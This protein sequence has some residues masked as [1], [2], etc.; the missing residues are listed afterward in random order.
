MEV[1]SLDQ[2]PRYVALS[3]EWGDPK[4]EESWEGQKVVINGEEKTITKNLYATLI[5]LRLQISS[6]PEPALETRFW[7]DA[8]CVNQ[9]DDD[10]KA[11]QVALMG[12]I[13]SMA[14]CVM[15]WVGVDRDNS[16]LALAFIEEAA[17]SPRN[18]ERNGPSEW[19]MQR[20]N[21]PQYL[22]HWMAF[23]HLLQGH[24]G[25][26]SGSPR[27]LSLRQQRSL[28]VATIYCR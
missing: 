22:S 2:G 28:S 18:E 8:V 4:G 14:C 9:D 1:V 17:R 15:L 10:E 16:N 12:K 3:Y 23:G 13:Y 21:D 7:I 26:V 6:A 20:L 27:R 24:I 5:Y 19:Y 25:G 11:T